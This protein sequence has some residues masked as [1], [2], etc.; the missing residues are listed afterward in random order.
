M[1]KYNVENLKQLFPEQVIRDRSDKRRGVGG[2]SK[3]VTDGE[4]IPW[5]EEEEERLLLKFMVYF[6]AK[7]VGTT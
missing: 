1:I 2:P 5:C 7:L 6:I 3:V 4:L